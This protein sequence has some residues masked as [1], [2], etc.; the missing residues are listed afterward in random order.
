M[1]CKTLHD[2]PASLPSLLA[3]EANCEL[4]EKRFCILIVS[5][6]A[7]KHHL[8]ESKLISWCSAASLYENALYTIMVSLC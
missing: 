4:S 7:Y 8:L 1:S 2:L 3:H 5:V 6:S